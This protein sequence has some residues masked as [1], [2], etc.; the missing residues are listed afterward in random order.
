MSM[1]LASKVDEKIE[2]SQQQAQQQVPATAGNAPAPAASAPSFDDFISGAMNV[3]GYMKVDSYGIHFD[4]E[5]KSK[6]NEVKVKIDPTEIQI[7]QSIR[8]GNPP[9]YYKSYDGVSCVQGGTWQDAIQ[10]A[11]SVEPKAQPYQSA[12]IPMELIDSYGENYPAGTRLGHS[13]SPTNRNE[14]AQFLKR[15]REQGL[16]AN[17]VYATVSYK[18][19]TNKAGNSWGVLTFT[20]DGPAD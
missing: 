7:C 20:L 14:F 10:A 19:R 13:T 3:D 16:D 9:T 8:F 2:S 1:D 6:K 12:D 11:V 15:L 5:K 18:E 4:D 17:P